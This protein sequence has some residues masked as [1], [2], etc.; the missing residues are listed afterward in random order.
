MTNIKIKKYKCKCINNNHKYRCEVTNNNP[1]IF[2]QKD[3]KIKNIIEKVI[4]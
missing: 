4:K 1:F 3:N 2:C